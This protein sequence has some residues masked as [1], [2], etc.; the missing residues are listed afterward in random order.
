ME[1][2]II[3]RRVLTSYKINGKPKDWEE[4][5]DG[6]FRMTDINCIIVAV[7]ILKS[8]IF[9]YCQ[10]PV[11]FGFLVAYLHLDQDGA[12]IGDI[13]LAAA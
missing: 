9:R 10:R 4:T 3:K 11:S 12:G 1:A 5:E 8:L 6:N 7:A 13:A 2:V